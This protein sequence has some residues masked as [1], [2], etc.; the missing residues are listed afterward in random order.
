M[1]F[2]VLF[3]MHR[4]PAS[5]TNTEHHHPQRVQRGSPQ[6]WHTAGPRGEHWALGSSGAVDAPPGIPPKRIPPSRGLPGPPGRAL[7]AA[8]APPRAP[9]PCCC[10]T[11]APRSP[12]PLTHRR[13]AFLDRLLRVL[14]LEEVPVRGED[15]DG[16][17]VAHGSG[18][19]RTVIRAGRGRGRAYALCV[20]LRSL[21]WVT[22]FALGTRFALGYAPCLG[23][24]TL[25]WGERFALGY[26]L[27][28]GVRT[29]RWVTHFALACAPPLGVR[30]LRWGAHFAQRPALGARTAGGGP[31]A[32]GSTQGFG[33][34]GT[35]KISRCHG[36][37]HVPLS[38]VA[39][40]PVQPGLGHF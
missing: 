22:Q 20:G 3:P 17:V 7:S 34:E 11:A 37:G 10:S 5:R 12:R 40:S 15:G 13:G 29:L 19:T 6:A 16:A 24:R 21:R 31:A 4:E 35:L 26:A 38:Q 2:Q 1:H 23:V 27:S 30:A 32:A 36:Q 9:L 8:Q 25:R 39:P 14:H 33:V 28:V 18:R